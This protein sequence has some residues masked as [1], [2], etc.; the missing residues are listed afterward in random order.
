METVINLDPDLEQRLRDE[1]RSRNLE[2]DR[3]LNDVIR[4]GLERTGEQFVQKTYAM[5]PELVDITHALA[6]A[7]ES[8]TK[9]RFERSGWLSA[10]DHP[11]R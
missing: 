11:G 10:G 3:V 7:D 9:R 6:L 2:F 4:A 8:K 5:G 1:A